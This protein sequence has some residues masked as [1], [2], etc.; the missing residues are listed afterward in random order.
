MVG[1]AVSTAVELMARV[2]PWLGGLCRVG[3]LKEGE[4]PR[5]KVKTGRVAKTLMLEI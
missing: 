2:M 4:K 1:E 5:E 3:G